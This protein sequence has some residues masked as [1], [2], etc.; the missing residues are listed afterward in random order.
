MYTTKSGAKRMLVSHFSSGKQIFC[1]KKNG[2]L[3]E[4]VIV[5][6]SW[7][8]LYLNFLKMKLFEKRMLGETDRRESVSMGN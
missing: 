4:K 7:Y 8:W 1:S 3:Q 2:Y 5:L 6:S